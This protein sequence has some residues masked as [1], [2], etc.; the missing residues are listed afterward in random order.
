MT[1]KIFNAVFSAM[2][3]VVAVS[4]VI[5]IFILYNSYAAAQKSQLKTELS[6]VAGAVES[7]GISYFD[8]IKDYDCRL[9][10]IDSDGTVLFD[11]EKPAAEMDN[12]ADREE[13]KEA[14]ENGFGESARSSS[15]LK[16]TIYRAEKLN[17]GTILRVSLTYDGLPAMLVKMLFPLIYIVLAAL[18]LSFVGARLL[19][20]KIVEPL[21]SL[22]LDKPMENNAYTELSPL[23]THIENQQIQIKNRV[24]ELKERTNE[25]TAVI[26][27]MSE[28]LLLMNNKGEVI[29]LNPAAA[30]FFNTDLSAV[31]NSFFSFEKDKDIRQ[32]LLTANRNGK[33]DLI[34]ERNGRIY[35]LIASRI[36]KGQENS[37]E[38]VLVLDKTEYIL[39]ENRRREFTA[40]VSHEL[41]TPLHT[42]MGRAEL[43]EN[44][45]VKSEDLP[46]FAGE[47]REDA[48]R[49]LTL[50]EDI[51]RLSQLDNG[52]K[53][54]FE[55]LD[56]FKC[57]HT[58]AEL[59]QDY[60]NQHQIDIKISGE[61]AVING[62][63]RLVH[64]IIYNLCENAI[65]YNK[66][67]GF[68]E[69]N[70]KNTSDGAV[71]TVKDNGI[72]I[73]KEHIPRIYE[74]FY[75]VDKSRS[76]A[77]GGTGL[78]LSIVKHAAIYMHAE[79]HTE[80]ELGKG[81]KITVTFPPF[82]E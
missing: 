58:E 29:T 4:L 21:N 42:I 79:I 50:I 18:I 62:V 66:A 23:L 19:S 75:R 6:L 28:G 52:N 34:V 37:G 45:I 27:N 15:A 20:V 39:A 16:K 57:V 65:K 74:R 30:S 61:S 60:A 54:D 69:I 70:T 38:T 81:T 12:H 44:G 71:L 40:N 55:H 46:K 82:S 32:T 43:I 76:K 10:W 41:K 11:S 25:L 7:H 36:D 59:L 63:P 13:V 78:G 35:R 24:D 33:S 51:I 77:I 53:M 14:I 68:V 67:G 3:V 49:L 56:L 17:D 5:V 72:G 22:N 1:K 8:H 48:S 2:I 31:G 80:S 47:I 9:T 64:E 73:D 26:E